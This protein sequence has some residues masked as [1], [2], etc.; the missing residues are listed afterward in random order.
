VAEVRVQF[1]WVAI[2]KLTRTGELP[3]KGPGAPTIVMALDIH[4]HLFPRHDDSAEF[5]AAER[6]PAY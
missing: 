3:A 4:G 5:A 1:A 6:V 2:R